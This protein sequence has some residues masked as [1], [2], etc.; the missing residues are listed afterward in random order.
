MVFWIMR[1]VLI[2][3]IRLSQDGK[4]Q[5]TNSL[6]YLCLEDGGCNIPLGNNS[7]HLVDW[8][9]PSIIWPKYK[10]CCQFCQPNLYI[11]PN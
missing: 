3:E 10:I 8:K 11:L 5:A 6:V 1:W 4:D 2:R 7:Y 9:I